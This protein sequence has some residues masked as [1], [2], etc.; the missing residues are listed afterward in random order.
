MYLERMR[1]TDFDSDK[2]YTFVIPM[3]ATEQH[4]PFLAL[5]TDSF[6]ADRIIQEAEVEFSQIIFLPTMRI[7]CSEEHEGFM[8]TVWV[9]KDTMTRVLIDICNSLKPYAKSIAI[10]S[11][12]GGNLELLDQFVK[13]NAS[14]FG[15]VQIIHL[16]M[17]SEETE[18]KMREMLDGPTD[19]HAGNVE[20]SMMLAHDQLLADIPPAD[21][22]KRAIENPFS[23]NRLKDFSEDGIADSHP[24]WVVSKENGEKMI[25]WTVEDF[26]NVLGKSLKA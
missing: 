20:L 25:R 6:L 19:Q 5:G 4:G 13:D 14:S 24:K 7:T 8:G 3:G 9:S 23:T 1:T 10:T 18:E 26:K 16:P 11:F 2:K 21:Y 22:P 15:D 17:G 12:H